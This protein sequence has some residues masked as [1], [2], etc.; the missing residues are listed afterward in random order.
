MEQIFP[1]KVGLFLVIWLGVWLP[2]AVIVAKLT[3]YHPGQ[4]LQPQQK[5]VLVLSLYLLL[6]GLVWGLMHIEQTQLQD[7][8]WQ[9]PFWGLYAGGL[10]LGCAGVG[11]LFGVA[12][13]LGWVEGRPP[14]WRSLIL[15]WL[16]A[17]LISAAEEIVFRGIFL[18]FWQQQTSLVW[19]AVLSSALFALL[20]LIWERAQTMRQLPGLW[21]MGMVLVAATLAVDQ[22]GLAI[23]LHAGWII[24][25]TTADSSIQY[26]ESTPSWLLGRLPLTGLLDNALLLL[27]G[28]GLLAIG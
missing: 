21:L 24:G 8:G 22:L 25:M 12:I 17:S 28:I 2:I 13:A 7:Y 5:I 27:T 16:V 26:Q 1:G 20:H 10:A 3:G 15:L 6:P 19:A 18:N 14:N 4:P 23:G 9:W 11:L